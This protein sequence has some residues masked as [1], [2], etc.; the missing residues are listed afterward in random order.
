MKKKLMGL[1]ASLFVLV[2]IFSLYLNFRQNEMDIVDTNIP[3]SDVQEEY[4][5]KNTNDLLDIPDKT[6]T[7]IDKSVPLAVIDSLGEH[8]G[9]YYKFSS[10]NTKLSLDLFYSNRE[11]GNEI[12]IKDKDFSKFP[13]TML[14]DTEVTERKTV[15]FENC[16]FYSIASSRQDSMVNY[17][18]KNCSINNFTGSNASFDKCYFGGSILDALNPFRNV[19]VTNSFISDLSHPTTDIKELHSDG[20]QIYG[21]KGLDAVN[22]HFD[23]CRFEVPSIPYTM[24]VGVYVNSCISASLEYSNG[25]NLTFTNIIMN[26]GAYSIY[27]GVDAPFKVNDVKFQNV[28]VG[29]SKVWGN[30]YPRPNPDITYENIVDTDKLYVTTVKK[31][32]DDGIDLYV[33]NDTETDRKLIVITDDYVEHEY[34]I[35]G[36]PLVG[37]LSETAVN[38]LTIDDF[39]IDKQITINADT[40]WVI[41]YDESILTANQ[42]RYVNWGKDEVKSP[43]FNSLDTVSSSPE[44]EIVV[45][46]SSKSIIDDSNAAIDFSCGDDVKFTYNNGKLTLIG[47][48]ATY[49]YN[50]RKPAP[51]YEYRENINEIIID[52]GITYLGSQLFANCT[53]VTEVILPEGITGISANTFIGAAELNKIT[54][55]KSLKSIGNYAFLGTSVTNVNYLGTSTEWEKI[56]IG[57]YNDRILNAVNAENAEKE[58]IESMLPSINI[59]DQGEC[60][61]EIKWVL[62]SDGKIVLD[63][64]GDTFNYNSRKPSPFVQYSDKITEVKINDGITRVGAQLFRNVTGI[65]ELS[66]PNSVTSVGANSFIGCSSLESLSFT[67]NTTIFEN[68]SLIGTSITNV[69]YFGLE[70]DWLNIEFGNNQF[71]LDA[72]IVFK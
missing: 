5:K 30:I 58:F 10:N 44:L 54:F 12:L 32:T 35:K 57:L 11:L 2:V 53:N 67:K 70:D 17:V 15:V 65:S 23:N 27:A 60:G 16:K 38:A 41:C 13:F 36:S 25:S 64:Q 28:K 4:I 40:Q 42:I 33:T 18:F 48:G 45:D 3:K 55:P 39:S 43:V 71:I 8:D 56:D 24:N 69:V 19:T 1:L 31:N 47:S 49:N 22:I 37:K 63:G 26:G 62:Y 59:I 9:I 72:N 51:W 46:D 7:G 6:N 14:N 29:S 21:Y 20:V 68:Y 50:S 66:L 52:D 61:V 34:I